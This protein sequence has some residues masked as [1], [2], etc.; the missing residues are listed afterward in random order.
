MHISA[1]VD[2]AARALVA[3]ATSPETT[4]NGETIATEQ[5]LPV[6]FLENILVDLRRAGF[7]VSQRGNAGGYRLARPASEISLAEIFRA[8]EGPLAEV[9]GGR[10]EETAYVAPAEHL[11]DAWIAV[12]AALRMVLESVTV[13]DVASGRFPAR[14]RRLLADPDAWVIRGR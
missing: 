10:P 2:Y 4:V 7:V 8:L 13:A 11:L 14:V 1:R 9:R 6:K 12:R 5:G 3:L